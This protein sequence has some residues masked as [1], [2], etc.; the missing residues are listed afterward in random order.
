MHTFGKLAR[1]R[2]GAGGRWGVTNDPWHG[3]QLIPQLP[4][5]LHA[6]GRGLLVLFRCA[7]GG[8]WGPMWPQGPPAH[9][10]VFC[11]PR[12]GGFLCHLIFT[13]WNE[14]LSSRPIMQ[15]LSPGVLLL[16]AH[17]CP[18]RELRSDQT[19]QFSASLQT[20]DLG[21]GS[22]P[23]VALRLVKSHTGSGDTFRTFRTIE[24]AARARV[25]GCSGA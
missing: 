2:S 10:E 8:V 6:P 13:C 21:G 9:L 16:P 20:A 15:P 19:Q 7:L 1:S 17:V 12:T 11:C 18:C 14:N 3:L 4:T 5:Q 22:L 25:L 24:K 23:L